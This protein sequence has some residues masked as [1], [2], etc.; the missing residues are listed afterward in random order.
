MN[1]S[2]PVFVRRLRCALFLSVGS[3]LFSAASAQ[4]APTANWVGAIRCEILVE[5][6]GYAHQETQT[7][8]LPGAAP[9]TQGAMKVYPA[10]WTVAGQGWHDRTRYASRRIAKW[11]TSVP[12]TNAP[13]KAPVAFLNVPVTGAL[14]VQLWHAQLV[15]SGGATG[16]DDYFD[17]GIPKSSGR[18]V[19]SVYEWQF[20]KIEG[21]PGAT[22]LSGSNTVE[23]KA[24]VGPVQPGDARVTITCT[25]EL[26]IGTAKPLPPPT[27]PPPPPYPGGSTTPPAGTSTP[28]TSGTGTPAGSNTPPNNGT[29][30]GT[31][32]NPANQ[33][34]LTQIS[35]DRAA[36]GSQSLT[37][38]LTGK[39]TTWEQGKVAALFGASITTST[40]AVNSPTSASVT[41]NIDAGAAQGA[42]DVTVIRG[43]PGV[44]GEV[45]RLDGGFTVTSPATTTPGTTPGTNPGGGGGSAPAIVSVTPNSGPQALYALP[46]AIT[47]QNTHWQAGATTVDFGAGITTPF[48]PVVKTPTTIDVTLYGSGYGIGT[49]P[50]TLTVTTGAEVLTL[51]N[52]FSVTPRARPTIKT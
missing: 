45:V 20:P 22:Q 33:P 30:P 23:V 6:S 41:L 12:G 7:W 28:P 2:R 38:T 1:H 49:G 47:G 16:T 44:V 27:L 42:R 24:G 34:V 8:T 4:P 52:G 11:T 21:D 43:L 14:A 9:T 10:T 50:R 32:A 19:Q 18:L 13:I 29:S 26:G 40:L 35:P 5:A 15:A 25:W 3:A 37:V 17:S 48:G 39:F 31:P 51:P 46:V 36:A